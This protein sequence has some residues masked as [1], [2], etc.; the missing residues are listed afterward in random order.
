MITFCVGVPVLA[1]LRTNTVKRHPHNQLSV[2]LCKMS[3]LIEL[4]LVLPLE[5]HVPGSALALL[6]DKNYQI[7]NFMAKIL[8]QTAYSREF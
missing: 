8:R 5:N 1:Y 6:G 4:K 7:I 3:P 2:H